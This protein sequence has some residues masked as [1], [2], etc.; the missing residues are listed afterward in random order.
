MVRRTVDV[1]LNRVEGDLEFQLEMEGDTVV[2]ARCIGTLYRGFEQ[3]LVGRAPRDSLV[4]TPRVCG[5]CGTAHLYA[6]TLAL[7]HLAGIRPPAHAVLVRNL[8]LTAETVQSD[9]RQSFLFFMP[10][11]CHPRYA[12]GALAPALHEA[13][14]PLQG[15]VVRECLR[16]TRDLLGL[17][18]VF[19]GQWPHSSHIL[20][21]G[22][23]APATPRRLLDCRNILDGTRRWFEASL[24]GGPLDDWLALD[25]A[26]AFLAWLASPAA[27]AGA[28]GLFS[29]A[30]RDLGLHRQGAGTPH[31]LSYGHW[32]EADAAP[33]PSG[34]PSMRIPGGFLEGGPGGGLRPL[35]QSL[36]NEHVRHSWY[37]D[38]PGGRHPWQ[39]ETIPNHRPGDDRYTWA[40]A[41]RYGDRV[42]QT[43]PLAQLAVAGEPLV[44]SLLD[45][46]GDSTWLRQFARLRRAG[47]ALGLMRQGLDEL[48]RRLDEPH[49]EDPGIDAWPD[50]ESFGMI[51]AARGALGHWLRVRDGRIDGY[52]IV[53]PTAWNA[54]P[55]DSAGRRG[56]WEESVIGLRVADDAD[57]VEVGHVVRSHDPCLVCTVHHIGSGRRTTYGV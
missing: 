21:G 27:A 38:Y 19:G 51:E 18:A 17:V 11:L 37:L 57:P 23:T 48:A 9:L 4:I 55:R 22:V 34:A 40:K 24:L 53:T 52:Q 43:G 33:G 12:G 13:F 28:I 2:D 36:I 29:R 10:D 50:G 42:V 54:S 26:E 31:M 46:E 5:I 47:Q 15:R 39:G 14:A 41:P 56:H 20:P 49:Y 30:C 45:A 6:A 25:G 1:D 35:D 32:C 7:E 3:I 44:R 8:C 16:A